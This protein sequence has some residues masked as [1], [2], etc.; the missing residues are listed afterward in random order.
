MAL[1]DKVE[2]VLFDAGGV[3][4]DLDFRYLRRLCRAYGVQTTEETLSR[5]EATARVDVHRAVIDG[6]RVSDMWR[7]YFHFI[8]GHV[9]VPVDDQSPIIDSLWEA[10]QKFGLWTVA[11]EDAVETVG[12]LK[13]AG[14]RIGV[15]SNA[16]GRVAHDLEGAGFKGLFETVVDSH[17][18]GVE[19]PDPKIF[20][21]AMERMGVGTETTIYVGDV[22]AVD[23]AGARAAGLT[24]L[25]IDRHDLYANEDVQRLRGIGELRG[26]LVD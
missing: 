6:A 24:P 4:L 9:G 26:L 2:T 16:E 25:L 8:L 15:V 22:P 19:K 12:Q 18:V 13:Q 1:P 21:I 23:V 10:H 17:H 20:G 5:Y 14:Y 3:L 7:D 11:I